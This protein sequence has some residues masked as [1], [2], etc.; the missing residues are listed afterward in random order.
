MMTLDR[1]P[2]CWQGQREPA[3]F[4]QL[5]TVLPGRQES[6]YQPQRVW[7]IDSHHRKLKALGQATWTGPNQKVFCKVS[8]SQQQGTPDL[9][10]HQT[11]LGQG[12]SWKG[13]GKAERRGERRTGKS[14]EE[15]PRG[16]QEQ[17]CLP[18]V[19]ALAALGQVLYTRDLTDLLQPLRKVHSDHLHVAGRTL[20]PER[21]RHMR[22]WGLNW[23]KSKALALGHTLCTVLF[24]AFIPKL[25]GK[26]MGKEA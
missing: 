23:V 19:L 5:L 9:S 6:S 17:P 26:T 21:L 11:C 22:N 12:G 15:G 2:A 25:E 8:E 14:K 4:P 18:R 1:K 16:L 24:P 20:K 10:Y 13:R 7:N 3:S